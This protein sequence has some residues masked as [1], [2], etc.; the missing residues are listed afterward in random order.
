MTAIFSRGSSR[1]YVL[2]ANALT[3]FFEARR[4]AAEKVRH[5]LGEAARQDLPL[6]M[7]AVNWGEV[8]YMEWRYRGEAKARE[9]EASLL[10]MPIAVIAVD[11]ERAS[12]AGAL[13]QKHG[14]GYADA[15][16]A[17]LAIERGALLVTADPEFQKVGRGLAVYPLPRYEK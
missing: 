12:R 8:F 11:R 3:A 2:D 16:A 9:A 10:E 7:S 15:F 14:L 13:K 5:L 1:R 17:E 4:G 6:L